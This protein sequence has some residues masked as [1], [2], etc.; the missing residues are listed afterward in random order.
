AHDGV[1]NSRIP[2]RDGRAANQDPLIT[3]DPPGDQEGDA[4]VDL[5][6]PIDQLEV[7][8]PRDEVFTDPL[9]LVRL[10]VLARVERPV[11][12]GPHRHHRRLLLLQEAGDAGHGAT[13]AEAGNDHVD[14]AVGLRPDFRAGRFVVGLRV[15][16]VE[17]L[18]RLKGARD[19]VTE[20]LGD[21]VVALRRIAWN[22]R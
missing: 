6:Y 16:L 13:G 22:R 14:L 15:G 10:R 7:D 3:G 1:L 20:P 12:V 8:R 11:R 21:R 9:D 4:V 2:G 19:L 17:V 5:Y 18:V